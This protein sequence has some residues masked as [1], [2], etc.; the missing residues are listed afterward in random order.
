M[1]ELLSDSWPGP[2]H[3]TPCHGHGVPGHEA[4]SGQAVCIVHRT[5]GGHRK[6]RLPDSPRKSLCFLNSISS[7]HRLF[8]V[9]L[10]SPIQF[11]TMMD[12]VRVDRWATGSACMSSLFWHIVVLNMLQ[13]DPSSHRL[14]STFSSQTYRSIPSSPNLTTTASSSSS[15]SLLVLPNITGSF[16]KY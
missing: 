7:P 2:R 12:N 10:I 4:K 13:M 1:A 8:N 5:Q 3:A 14:T 16:V 6:Q 9:S 15:I 11:K